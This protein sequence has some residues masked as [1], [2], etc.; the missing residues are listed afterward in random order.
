VKNILLIK[1]K[2]IDFF[3]GNTVRKVLSVFLA[4]VV[5]FII[6]SSLNPIE[7]K[8]FR[9]SYPVTAQQLKISAEASEIKNVNAV[10]ELKIDFE[11]EG[12]KE[13]IDNATDKDFSIKLDLD[14]VTESKEYDIPVIVVPDTIGVRVVSQSVKTV[15]IKFEKI[16]TK[17]IPIKVADIDSSLLGAED[18]VVFSN[19]LSPSLVEVTGF[20]SIVGSIQEARIEITLADLDNK[21]LS[22]ERTLIKTWKYYDLNGGEVAINEDEMVISERVAI[23]PLKVGKRVTLKYNV[24]GTPGQDCYVKENDI[25][26]TP[27]TVVVM[28][29]ASILADLTVIE[30]EA[31]SVDG[32]TEDVRMDNV[33]INLPAGLEIAPGY[34]S[35]VTVEVKLGGIIEKEIAISNGNVVISDPNVDKYVYDIESITPL[36]VKG[37][38]VEVDGIKVTDLKAK[39]NVNG[40]GVGTHI[41]QVTVS[42]NSNIEIKE[43]AKATVRIREKEI[44]EEPDPS[45]VD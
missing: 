25:L 24:T 21:P 31:I 3:K 36:K 14:G 42:L 8:S 34:P 23:V 28:G 33:S 6:V 45:P 22:A 20:E 18:Y 17:T 26:I 16:I 12:R 27:K 41:I 4:C 35:E 10:E 2:V 29:P 38:D 7:K 9:I 15:K 19:E 11:I 43:Y 40:L 44:E 39:V 13:V 32:A 37:M 30:T 1:E 5:W